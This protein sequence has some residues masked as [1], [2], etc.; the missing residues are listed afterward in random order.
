M[1]RITSIKDREGGTLPIVSP[2][3]CLAK[4]DLLTTA[5]IETSQPTN[6]EA[7]YI[8][9]S[10]I[11]HVAEGSTATDTDAPIDARGGV[12]LRA[13]RGSRISVKLMAGEDPATVWIH[14]VR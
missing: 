4:K 1:S 7:I 14:G 5:Q 10:S 8:F 12:Y 11:I 3:I 13:N 9:C 2:G 6:S